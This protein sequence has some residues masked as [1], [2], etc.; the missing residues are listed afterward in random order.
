[1]KLYLLEKFMRFLLKYKIILRKSQ[2]T[3]TKLMFLYLQILKSRSE[4]TSRKSIEE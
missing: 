1:M 4:L 3:I 2:N